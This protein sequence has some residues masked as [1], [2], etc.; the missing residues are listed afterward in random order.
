MQKAIIMG[1]IHLKDIKVY[2]YHGCL[3]EEAAIGS[4]YFVNL[5]VWT[6]LLTSAI[7]DELAD[8]I[9]YVL[10]NRIVKEEMAIRSKLLEHVNKRIVDRILNEAEAVDKVMVSI[11]KVNPPIGGDVAEVSVSMKIER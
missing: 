11:A 5:K 8:T 1:V 2:S 6:N 4:E 7:S 3:M 10:L 9:D